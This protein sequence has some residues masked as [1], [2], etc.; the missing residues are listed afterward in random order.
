MAP[1]QYLLTWIPVVPRLVRS[2]GVEA[3]HWCGDKSPGRARRSPRLPLRL[4]APVSRSDRVPPRVLEEAAK[5]AL[6]AEEQPLSLPDEPGLGGLLVEL[7]AAHRIGR[8]HGPLFATANL[9][10]GHGLTD[11][12]Q[13]A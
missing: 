2:M 4:D 8:S 10:E 9:I 5:T 3:T 13:W 7:H 11:A 6:R 1:R 12:F